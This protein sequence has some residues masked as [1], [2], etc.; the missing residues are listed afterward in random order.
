[1][2]PPPP[3]NHGPAPTHLQHICR[4]LTKARHIIHPGLEALQLVCFLSKQSYAIHN[5]ILTLRA[6]QV[7]A[8]FP[9]PAEPCHPMPQAIQKVAG[10]RV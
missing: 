5:V 4:K 2:H 9:K 8:A 1:M 10:A 7:P 3:L 6:P